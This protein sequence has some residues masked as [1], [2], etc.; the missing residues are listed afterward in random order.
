MVSSKKPKYQHTAGQLARNYPSL[1]KIQIHG[2]SVIE[3]WISVYYSDYKA[4]FESLDFQTSN[5]VVDSV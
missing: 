3:L 1:G 2:I 5:C 4:H